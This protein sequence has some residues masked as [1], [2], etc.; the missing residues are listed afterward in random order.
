MCG[1]TGFKLRS[2]VAENQLRSALTN[3]TDALQHRGPDGS[4]AWVDTARGMALGHRRLAILDL[5]PLGAQPMVSHHGRYVIVFNGEVYNAPDLRRQLEA[6]G[7]VFRGSSDTEVMLE[8]IAN[9]GLERAIAQFLGMFAFAVY[10]QEEDILTLVRD[11]LGVKPLYWTQNAQ[12]FA[13]ASELRALRV[14]PWSARE[15]NPHALEAYLNLSFVPGEHSILKGIQ[16]LPPGHMLRLRPDGRCEISCYWRIQDAALGVVHSPDLRS[17]ADISQEFKH[18]VDDAVK[19]RLLSDVPL[20]AF[21][22]GGIDSSTVVALMRRHVP[23]RVRTF[24]I[25]FDVATHDEADHAAAVARALDTDHTAFCLSA[26]D[27]ESAVQKLPD[28]ADEPLADAS[29]IP[30]M[31]VASLTRQHVT[32]ALSGDGGDEL[33]GGYARHAFAQSLWPKING[34]PP[35]LRQSMGR[36]LQALPSGLIERTLSH[37]RGHPI[38]LHGRLQKL[39]V[40]LQASTLQQAYLSSLHPWQMA[41]FHWPLHTQPGLSPLAQMQAWDGALY[42]PDDVLAKVDRATMHVGLEAREPLLD[43]RLVEFCWRLPDA[44]RRSHGG[45]KVLLRQIL[46][47]HVPLSLIDR[48]KTGFSVPLEVWLRGGLREMVGDLMGLYAPELEAHWPRPARLKLWDDFQ[49]HKNTHSQGLWVLM[50][51]LLWRQRWLN[52]G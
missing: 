38:Q 29:L 41:G 37:V 26:K 49:A 48:P 24:S 9:W 10:D 6:E 50:V 12:G 13:F 36:V 51:Y 28:I 11:R 2:P 45:G 16:R 5:S 44:M 39:A 23:H 27:A 19:R 4:G 14:A 8:A 47:K 46:Q 35:V 17:A 43:H 30:T 33:L 7:A 52:N 3:M 32:V 42:L 25:G 34:L 18:L 21:L 40:A 22:S 1:I 31:L 15:V 20:G